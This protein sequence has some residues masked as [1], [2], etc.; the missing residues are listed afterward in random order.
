M[1]LKT[2]HLRDLYDRA[3]RLG[4]VRDCTLYWYITSEATELIFHSDTNI[5]ERQSG[6]GGQDLPIDNRR[7]KQLLKR[8][9]FAG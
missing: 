3:R 8:T 9:E 7:A 5:L 2:R 1:N 6:L 4:V